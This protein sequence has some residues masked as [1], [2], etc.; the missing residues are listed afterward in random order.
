MKENSICTFC[1]AFNFPPEWKLIKHQLNRIPIKYI[2]C[3]NIDSIFMLIRLIYPWNN[4]FILINWALINGREKKIQN[5]NEN[6][7]LI[8]LHKKK[9]YLY[10]SI[11]WE[12][13]WRDIGFFRMKDCK[14][15]AALYISVYKHFFIF[16]I[17]T[18][19][20]KNPN[21]SLIVFYK[22]PKFDHCRFESGEN[23]RFRR[24]DPLCWIQLKEDGRWIPFTRTSWRLLIEYAIN[25]Y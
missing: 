12:K 25:C 20:R 14:Q 21:V 7:K 3:N 8:F 18:K 22:N 19:K 4:L 6:E 13:E 11:W 24:I 5:I 9:H 23:T 17:D 1:F 2:L 10:Y 16:H 15:V